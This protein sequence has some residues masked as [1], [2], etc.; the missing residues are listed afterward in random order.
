[1][2]YIVSN[3]IITL[4]PYNDVISAKEYEIVVHDFDE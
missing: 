3:L 2:N 4:N 1:M